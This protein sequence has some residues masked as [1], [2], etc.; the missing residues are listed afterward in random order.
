MPSP[1]KHVGQ[2]LAPFQPLLQQNLPTNANIDIVASA[3][4]L[5]NNMAS[6]RGTVCYIAPKSDGSCATDTMKLSDAPISLKK[7]QFPPMVPN[8]N[9]A[10]AEIMGSCFFYK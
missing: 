3:R 5:P 9:K 8:Q 10:V 6:E 7:N 4:C 1:T 2:L